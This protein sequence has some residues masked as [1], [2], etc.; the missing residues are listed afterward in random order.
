MTTAD[1]KKML[2]ETRLSIRAEMEQNHFLTLHFSPLCPADIENA[3]DAS[4]DA[5]FQEVSKC[6]VDLILTEEKL[7]LRGSMGR[8]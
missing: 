8:G 6:L 1:K 5:I 3:S 2:L 7:G 4:I